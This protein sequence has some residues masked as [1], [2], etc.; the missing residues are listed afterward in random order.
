[1]SWLIN[2]YIQYVNLYANVVLSRFKT[3]N[4]EQRRGRMKYPNRVKLAQK[5][6]FIRDSCRIYPFGSDRLCDRGFTVFNVDQDLYI[7]I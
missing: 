1:M 6:E 5:S 7:Y 4:R 3:C 2:E